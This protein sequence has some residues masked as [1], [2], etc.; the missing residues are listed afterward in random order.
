MDTPRYICHVVSQFLSEI[1]L[2]FYL[3]IY[4]YYLFIYL[5][6]YFANVLCPTLEYFPFPTAA[7]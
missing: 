6:I 4:F 3:I 5:Y 7:A 2:F 1:Y